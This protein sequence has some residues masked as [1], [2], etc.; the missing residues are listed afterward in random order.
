MP[1]ALSR[2]RLR[3]PPA[4]PRG[5]CVPEEDLGVGYKGKGGQRS[6]GTGSTDLMK[7]TLPCLWMLLIRL[8]EDTKT[9]TKGQHTVAQCVRWPFAEEGSD[10]QPASLQG[11]EGR[12][13][14]PGPL[15]AHLCISHVWELSP[16]VSDVTPTGTWPIPVL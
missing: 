1:L 14:L 13:Q 12:S 3:G 2:W 4:C 5:T 11:H 9:A 6:V 7:N 16:S 15:L 10:Q 8:S